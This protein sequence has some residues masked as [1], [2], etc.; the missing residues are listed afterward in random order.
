MGVDG[1]LDNSAKFAEFAAF[2]GVGV[3]VDGTSDTSAKF[4]EF[5][6]FGG[7]GVGIRVSITSDKRKSPNS[8]P[9]VGWG[10]KLW[11]LEI[12]KT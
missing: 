2:G 8:L 10:W 9:S 4:A 7:G 3:G 1:I 5:A 6:A 11:V 12:P